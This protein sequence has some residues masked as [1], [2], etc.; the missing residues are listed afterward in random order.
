MFMVLLGVGINLAVVQTG[1][2]H[3]TIQSIILSSGEVH[4]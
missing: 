2:I 3:N 4:K 1:I